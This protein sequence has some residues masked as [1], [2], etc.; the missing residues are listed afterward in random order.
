MLAPTSAIGHWFLNVEIRDAQGVVL[1]ELASRFDDVAHQ[2]G[3]DLVGDVRLRNLD[4]K[5]RPIRRIQ[6][7]LPQLLCIHL[8][9][10]FVALNRQALAATSKDRVEEFGWPGDRDL[11]ALRFR[12]NLLGSL[13]TFV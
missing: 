1:N 13:L 8:T 11:L 7:R 3:E 5:E 6:R 2:A 4:S 10:A 12:F 9:K